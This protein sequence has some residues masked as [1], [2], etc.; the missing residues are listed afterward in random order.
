MG[1]A[2]PGIIQHVL[3]LR[4]VNS[5]EMSENLQ[6]TR[7]RE[8]DVLRKVT[9]QH[10]HTYILHIELQAKN[11]KD[12]IYRMVEYR[13]ML[14]RKYR[15]PV[16]QYVL[17]IGPDNMTMISSID[18]ENFTFR[19]KVV[20]LKE[21]DYKIFLHSD[22]PEE[23]VFAI[24]ANLGEDS[25]EKVVKAIVEDLKTVVDGDNDKRK[26]INQLKV[27]VHLLKIKLKEEDME[28][29]SSFFTVED[30]FVYIWGKEKGI[31]EGKELGI[32]EGKEEGIKIGKEEAIN[33]GRQ[34]IKETALEMKKRG[35]A[36]KLISDV[37][38]LPMEEIETL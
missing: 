8:P 35:I 4:I 24:L 18:E 20:S 36:L 5:E 29:V 34:L 14:Q 6:H 10:N 3:N 30:D 23:K 21:F 9:D 26:Y 1:I 17:Y 19:Y 12:M 27:L 28:P 22:N 16:K 13:V 25:P 15:I 37:T 33:V 31:K 7:E 32:K 11:E 38:K 2:L